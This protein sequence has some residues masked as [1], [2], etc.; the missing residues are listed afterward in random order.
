MSRYHDLTQTHHVPQVSTGRVI[1]PSEK[2][3][4]VKLQQTQIETTMTQTGFKPVIIKSERPQI[5]DLDG[6]ATAI[7]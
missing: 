1:S 6:A 2:P 7:G 3:V 5:D 4:L